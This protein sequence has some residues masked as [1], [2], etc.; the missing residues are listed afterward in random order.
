MNLVSNMSLRSSL[1]Q[2]KS[3]PTIWT[4]KK[5]ENVISVRLDDVCDTFI[6]IS[7]ERELLLLF[8]REFSLTAVVEV[9]LKSAGVWWTK[10]EQMR[11][12][13][14]RGA[15]VSWLIKPQMLQREG[16]EWGDD[17]LTWYIDQL[18]C[19]RQRRLEA[20]TIGVDGMRIDNEIRDSVCCTEWKWRPRRTLESI[21]FVI[22]ITVPILERRERALDRTGAMWGGVWPYC[23]G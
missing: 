8:L 7:L 12:N 22:G 3:P 6:G 19:M 1:V 10:S 15:R 23:Y 20:A 14:R 11:E 4:L 18:W 9:T 16:A 13:K 17:R 5:G 2:A 21:V